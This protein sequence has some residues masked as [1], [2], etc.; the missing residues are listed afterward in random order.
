MEIESKCSMFFLLIHVHLL[1][2]FSDKPTV[3]VTPEYNPYNVIENTTNLQ[4]TCTVTDAN[5]AATS[6]RWFEGNSL[7]SNVDA[8]TI[9][10]V[11]RSHTG[12]YRCDAT[13]TVGSSIPSPAVQLNI[14]C[15]F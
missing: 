2:I 12:S 7:I 6:Y 10:T 14:L 8:Y 5:P 9:P 11:K 13:N 4:I 15:K 3:T 1:C